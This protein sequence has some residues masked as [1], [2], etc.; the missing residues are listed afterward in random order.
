MEQPA[1]GIWVR[2]IGSTVCISV[3]GRATR[4]HGPQV[5]YFANAMMRRGYDRFELDL[6]GC[7]DLDSTF[8]GVLASLSS[9]LARS[10]FSRWSVKGISRQTLSLFTALGI[11]RLFEMNLAATASTPRSNGNYASFGVAAEQALH[12]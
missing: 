12:G 11:D 9:R 5:R 2:A 4:L 3:R 7:T 8:L 1:G 6:D 10:G